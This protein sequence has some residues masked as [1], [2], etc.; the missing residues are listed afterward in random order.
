MDGAKFTLCIAGRMPGLNEMIEAAKGTGGRGLKYSTMKKQWT[1]AC[2]LA[3]R[4]RRIPHMDRIF[5]RFRWTEP[6]PSKHSKVRDPDNV[7]AG[8]KFV[9]DG[10]V[11]AGILD[12]DKL[13]QVAGWEDSFAVGGS[14]SVEVTILEAS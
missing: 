6:A 3:A 4:A 9:L 8:R 2:A 11:S 10:L 7:A 1:N 5:L 13:A 14:G 12:D